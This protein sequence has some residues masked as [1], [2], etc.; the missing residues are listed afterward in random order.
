MDKVY[1]LKLLNFYLPQYT[2][3]EIIDI[4]ALFRMKLE[5]GLTENGTGEGRTFAWSDANGEAMGV[6][7]CHLDSGF[8][9][10]G[11]VEITFWTD[12]TASCYVLLSPFATAEW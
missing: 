9:I 4:A 2:G 8:E 10:S 11:V 5:S 3:E 7:Y 12:D 1:T 6:G